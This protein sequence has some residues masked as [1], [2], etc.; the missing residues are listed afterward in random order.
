MTEDRRYREGEVAEIFEI[1]AAPGVPKRTAESAE[2]FTVPELIAIGSEVGIP[3]DRIADAARS[4]ARR[5]EPQRKD[6]GMI[7]SARRVVDLPRALTDRE[8]AM[9]VAELR[10]TFRARGREETHGET[11]HWRN[12]NL[13]AFVEP[14]ATGYRLRLGTVKGNAIALNRMGA[15]SAGIG[16]LSLAAMALSGQPGTEFVGPSALGLLGAGGFAFNAL[17]LPRWVREREAQMDYIAA[18]ARALV[19]ADRGAATLP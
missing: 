11:R 18:Q 17:R 5:P 4:L 15:V 13:H 14:T 10:E 16:A 9:L 2:G 7:V 3:A 12:S 6:F 19:T 8:W 1:A